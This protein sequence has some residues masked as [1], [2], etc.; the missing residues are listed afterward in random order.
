MYPDTGVYPATLVGALTLAPADEVED[1]DGDDDAAA[2]AAAAA[3]AAAEG[4]NGLL[5]GPAIGCV[6][7]QVFDSVT[8]RLRPSHPVDDNRSIYRGRSTLA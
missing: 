7:A 8:T 2:V 3:A 1:A 5:V 6:G 4:K